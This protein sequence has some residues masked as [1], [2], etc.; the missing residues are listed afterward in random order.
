MKF[1]MLTSAAALIGASAALAQ[2]VQTPPQRPHV[3]KVHSRADVQNRIVQHF[4]RLDANRDGFV[5]QAEVQSRHAQRAQKRGERAQ[6]RGERAFDRIDS[7][8]DGQISRA[9][10]AA[11]PRRG[12]RGMRAAGM[13]AG[14]GGR[15]FGM[16][17]LDRDGRVSLAEAQQAAL[18]RFDRLDLNRDGRLTPEERRQ[19]RERLRAQRRPG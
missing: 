13:R 2:P 4:A 9:E 5:T 1:L 15:M 14:F 12:Q 18:Q 11:A 19:A 8:K 17:D 10:F 7:N 3:A 16:A 6:R